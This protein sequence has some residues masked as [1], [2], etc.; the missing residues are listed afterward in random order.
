MIA[1]AGASF[2]LDIPDKD[3]H[4]QRE[5]LE[6]L[7]RRGNRRPELDV[8]PIPLETR[9]LI[10]WFVDLAGDRQWGMGGPGS[11]TSGMILDWCRGKGRSL[12]GWEFDMLRVLDRAWLAA[13][14]EVRADG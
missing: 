5:I 1:A 10:E 8:E 3:G 12:T 9:Y 14:N 7:E 4:T 6:G 13:W 2:R 11:L